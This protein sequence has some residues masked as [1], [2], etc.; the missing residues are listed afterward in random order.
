MLFVQFRFLVFF[1]IVFAVHWALRGNTARKV[2]LLICS[3]VFYA[4]LFLGGPESAS[5]DE[6]PLWTFYKHLRDGKE[7]PVGWWF[8]VVLWASTIMD[9]VVG[10]GIG[11]SQLEWKRRAWLLVSICANLGVL[12]FFKYY[13]F[14]V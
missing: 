5:A 3:H 1:L 6:F 2:W 13:N 9:Y 7:L 12:G 11:R 14:F 8:P 4:C 10:L